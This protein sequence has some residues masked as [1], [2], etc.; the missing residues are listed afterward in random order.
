MILPDRH[1]FMQNSILNYIA[2]VIK[3]LKSK[4]NME[5]FEL[6]TEISKEYSDIIFTDFLY[7]LDV[8]YALQ[9]I[10]YDK[11]YLSLRND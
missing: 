5:P 10:S 11:G 4:K 2:Q 7:S 1:L 9:K 3:Y 6:F 8:L